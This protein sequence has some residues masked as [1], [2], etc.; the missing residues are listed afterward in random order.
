MVRW[1]LWVQD[2][3]ICKGYVPDYAQTLGHEFV[4]TVEESSSDAVVPGTRVVGEDR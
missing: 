4:G 2:I 1:H 3:E